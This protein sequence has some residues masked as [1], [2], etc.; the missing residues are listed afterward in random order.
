MTAPSNATATV[1]GKL[2]DAGGAPVRDAKVCVATR[3]ATTEGPP[4]RVIATPTTSSKGRFRTRLKAGPS[5][6]VRVAHWYGP[7]EVTERF[8]DLNSKAVPRLAVRPDNVRNG[9]TRPLRRPHPRTSP[10]KPPNRHPGKRHRQVDPHRRRPNRPRRPLERQ[11]PLQANHRHPH[12]RLPSRNP[13]PTGLPV[14]PRP[15]KD[16]ARVDRCSRL[17]PRASLRY[18]RAA[19]RSKRRDHDHA[20]SRA[21]AWP[22]SARSSGSIVSAR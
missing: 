14:L 6:E 16:P 19:P 15:L 8:L 22:A 11:V 13:P 17:G 21:G 4:E 2:T 18:P 20:R 5:R 9:Q 12:L 7:H 3:V 1:I 10:S